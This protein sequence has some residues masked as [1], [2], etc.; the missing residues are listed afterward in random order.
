MSTAPL[1]MFPGFGD[2]APLE[3]GPGALG[4][5]THG[6][7]GR[8]LR[9][10]LEAFAETAAS[11]GYCSNPI[12]LAGSSMTVD[13]ATGEVV[14][15]FSSD[16]APMGM[17]YRPCGNRR[18]DVCPA[19]SRVYARDTFAMIRSGLLGGKTVPE[20]VGKNPLVFATLTAPSFG[21]VHG[22][23]SKDGD[24]T[25]G[26][27]RPFDRNKVCEHGRSMSCMRKHTEN[28]PAVG[29]PLCWDCYDWTC[30]VVWQW[31][32]PELWRRFTIALRR[33]VAAHLGKTDAELRQVASVQ[34]AKVGEYQSRGLIHFHALIRLD[35]PDGPGTSAPLNGVTLAGLVEKAA[36]DVVV[37]APPV[38][39]ADVPRELAFGSQL[40]ARTVRTGL[41]G[42][43]FKDAHSSDTLVPEQVAAYL[44]KYATK[45]TD[46]DPA[47]PRPHL[48]RMTREC[49]RLA[50]RAATAC[51][52][53]GYEPEEDDDG[54]VCG[55]CAESPY[56]LLAKW[57]HM[58]G[59]RGHFSSKSRKYSVTLG[60]LRNARARF[61]RLQAE[62]QRSGEPMNVKDLERRLLADDEETTLVVDG[63]WNYVGTGWP[64]NGEKELAEAAAARAREYAQ[65]KA[66]QKYPARAA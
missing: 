32:A 48:S 18:A 34:Y 14:G 11:V 9:E 40:D 50:D 39:G 6:A 59:F 31:H 19:C 51:R 26:M 53:D 58:L 49:R 16:D 24:K 5:A 45:S 60:K 17:L 33:A 64:T 4:F 2:H 35:G 20:A 23:R 43:L 10:R 3:V 42:T 55:T 7:R 62:A 1:G 65:W 15:S 47:S 12:K 25:G 44:A 29:S 56:R 61:A 57:S 28:D 36:R 38:D 52:M 8:T 30:A 66:G 37:K 63:S 41:P 22:I 21:H 27:C 46:V 13:S 54:C